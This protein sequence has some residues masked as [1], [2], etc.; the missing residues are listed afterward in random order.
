MTREDRRSLALT[1]AAL[2]RLFADWPGS[3]P[4]VARNIEVM[5]RVGSCAEA[6]LRRWEGLLAA[7]PEAIAGAVLADTD[8]AQ[9][10][11]SVHPLSGL[12][13]PA[14]RWAVL[15]GAAHP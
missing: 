4:Q 3:A 10:L 13:T 9:V 8:E 12:L 14:E 7:G 6:Y 15:A 1:H 5:R 2:E 11:R